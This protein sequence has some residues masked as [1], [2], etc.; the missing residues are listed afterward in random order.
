MRFISKFANGVWQVFDTHHYAPVDVF[1]R[2]RETVFPTRKAV[3]EI[4]DRMNARR[5]Q[6]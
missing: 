3:A 5:A 4:C 1:E 6:R 2:E